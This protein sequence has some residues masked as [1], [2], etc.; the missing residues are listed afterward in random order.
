MDEDPV[1]PTATP[2]PGDKRRCAEPT[3]LGCPTTQRKVPVTRTTTPT[4]RAASAALVADGQHLRWQMPLEIAD[5]V[6]AVLDSDVQTRAALGQPV[7]AP[8]VAAL[9]PLR[10]AVVSGY[11]AMIA[12]ILGDA[13]DA[14][15]E[16]ALQDI[17]SGAL[18]EFRDNTRGGEVAAENVGP[19]THPP[20]GGASRRAARPPNPARTTATAG[21]RDTG[22][23]GG[24]PIRGS[25]GTASAP[26]RPPNR[27][28]A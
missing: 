11:D 3:A 8:L 6:L 12:E 17:E 26:E 23:T 2:L 10:E 24:P 22:P 9:H 15:V 20:G 19:A 16:E 5:A 7:A 1:A 13:M 28:T 21:G 4:P 25:G 14:I 18:D 27:L